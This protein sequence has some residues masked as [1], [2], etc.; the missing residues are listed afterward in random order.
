MSHFP[1]VIRVKLSS[2][3]LLVGGGGTEDTLSED[4]DGSNFED[5]AKI[6]L[7]F[8]SCSVQIDTLY[9]NVDHLD[10]IQGKN[11]PPARGNPTLEADSLR[12]TEQQSNNPPLSYP[13]TPLPGEPGPDPNRSL[14]L[15][16]RDESASQILSTGDLR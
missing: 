7:S 15:E 2:L 14:Q 13:T 4:F 16:V 10:D 9:Q 5:P 11:K 8:A 6:K 12:L 3:V 1:R